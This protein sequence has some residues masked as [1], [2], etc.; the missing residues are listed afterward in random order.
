[1]LKIDRFLKY[2]VCFHVIKNKKICE[3]VNKLIKA[4]IPYEVDFY[5][6]A[7]LVFSFYL[8]APEGAIT[9]KELDPLEHFRLWRMYN[10]YF[11]EHKPSITINY[12]DSNFLQLGAEIYKHFDTMTGI[13]LLPKD[14]NTYNQAPFIEITEEEYLKGIE[15]QPKNIN[16]DNEKY[17]ILFDNENKQQ[18]LGNNCDTL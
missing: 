5:S 13:A 6:K 12:N 10:D 7:N 2:P 1:M 14:D 15:N 18:C 16:W 9:T 17:N 8:K 4:N 11:C 3:S